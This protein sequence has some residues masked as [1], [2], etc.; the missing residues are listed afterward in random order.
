MSSLASSPT[1]PA[2]SS[3]TAH[4][5]PRGHSV[6]KIGSSTRRAGNPVCANILG[7]ICLPCIQRGVRLVGVNSY[8]CFSIVEIMGVEI[9]VRFREDMQRVKDTRVHQTCR[10]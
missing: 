2:Q 1:T 7:S 9:F 4:L 8:F 5:V 6:I 10:I 3:W